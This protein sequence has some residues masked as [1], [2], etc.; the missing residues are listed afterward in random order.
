MDR[1]NNRALKT[2]REEY[3]PALRE[4]KLTGW[5]R[6]RRQQIE[7]MSRF[8]NVNRDFEG[9]RF[10]T[11]KFL[12]FALSWRPQTSIDSWQTLDL[13]RLAFGWRPHGKRATSGRRWKISGEVGHC[14]SI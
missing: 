3:I 11:K 10:E 2:R 6:S 5:L 1:Q 13:S 9:S 7:L 8:S 14:A 12:G 4:A